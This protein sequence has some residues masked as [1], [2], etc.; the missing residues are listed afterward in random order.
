MKSW[1]G[2]TIV[3]LLVVSFFLTVMK[4]PAPVVVGG[5]AFDDHD[6]VVDQIHPSERPREG[7]EHDVAA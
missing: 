5:P 4:R 3:G 1:I 7:D 2:G 6:P